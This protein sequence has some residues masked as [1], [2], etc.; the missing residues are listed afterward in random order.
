MCEIG[1]WE[2]PKRKK[3][4]KEEVS[5]DEDAIEEDETISEDDDFE[6]HLKSYDDD[7]DEQIDDE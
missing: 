7:E 2:L 4:N 5:F 1:V 6:N 3:K